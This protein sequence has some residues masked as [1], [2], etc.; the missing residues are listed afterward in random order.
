MSRIDSSEQANESESSKISSSS[1]RQRVQWVDYVKGIGIFL[2]VLGHAIRGIVGSSVLEPTALV[3]FVDRWIYAFHMPLFFLVSG[4]FVQRSLRKP[5][6]AF[7]VDKL[8]VLVYP[9]FLWSILQTIIQLATYGNL[10]NSASWASVLKIIYEPIMQFW[11]IYTL[12]I[13]LILYGVAHRFG[14]SCNYLLG[15]ATLLY[16][17]SLADINFGSWGMLYLVRRNMIYF[18]IGAVLGSSRVL[19]RLREANT[20]VLLAIALGGYLGITL[21]VAQ[22]S[23]AENPYI[24]PEIALVG[25][26]ASIALSMLME[27]WNTVHFF[28]L[29]GLLSLQIYVA[30]TIASASVRIGLQKVLGISEPL[31]HLILGTAIGIYAPI[32]LNQIC[33]QVGFKYM[34][35]LKFRE[36]PNEGGI[37]R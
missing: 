5:F 31:T 2:V 18:S 9:Y 36:L 32:A 8:Q 21:I 14:I 30:H 24:I 11:F 17:A 27:R 13:I 23:L 25:I 12:F 33:Q 37:K 35:S 4:L 6:N 1:E 22:P 15:L 28:E 16:A 7:I 3:Q 26:A 19:V 29:W 10:K 20:L 34:F